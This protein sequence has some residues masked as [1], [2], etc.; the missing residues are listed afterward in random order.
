ME[1]IKQ[2]EL[3]H[4]AGEGPTIDGIVFTAPSKS[5]VIVAVVDP[6]R[7]PVFRTV[8]RDALTER[9]EDGPND[10]ALAL[11]VKRTPPPVGGHADGAGGS[12]QGR[13]GHSRAAMHR[14]TGK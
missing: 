1:S 4:V 10:T 7:G 12:R 2:G 6:R 9:T 11:L 5:K 8:H 13:S 3:V 14:T